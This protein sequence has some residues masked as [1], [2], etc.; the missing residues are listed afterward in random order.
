M[1]SRRALPHSF[2]DAVISNKTPNPVNSI[3]S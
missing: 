1:P 2:A 3:G